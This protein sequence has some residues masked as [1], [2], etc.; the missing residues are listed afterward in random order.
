MRAIGKQIDNRFGEMFYGSLFCNRTLKDASIGSFLS[1]GW[2][3]GFA[4]EFVGGALEPAVKRL[5]NAPTPTRALIRDATT[6][7][8]N[9]F[10]YAATAMIFNA[11]VNKSMT[12]ED[13]SGMDYI[14]PRIG[15]L[16]PDGSPRRISNP[17]YT[18]EVPMAMKNIEE[19]QSV[20][21]GL[22]QMLSHKLMFAP[23]VEMGTNRNY[24]GYQIYDENAPGFKQA[25]QF[26]KHLFTEQL[27]PMSITGAK[28]SLELSGKPHTA[29]DILKGA[30]SGDSDVWGPVMGFGPAPAYASKDAIDNRISYLFN[31]FIAPKEKPFRESEVAKERA[32]A[33]TAYMMARQRGDQPAIAEAAKKLATLGVKTQQIMKM[34]PGGNI[35]Y[36]FQRLPESQ[37]VDLLKQMPPEKF[38]QFYPKA[39]RKTRSDPGVI[40]LTRRYFQQSP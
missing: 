16:N 7:S 14:F 35:Q 25:Y 36:M 37:Q 3:L 19:R 39:S 10:L 17:F 26:G 23:F 8:T 6:K 4:R 21:G 22:A 12:G 1:L 11:M 30:L 28:R 5:G 27:S 20:I 15:G 13:A 32:E 38:K 34:Q 2:N 31:K 40:A 33:R 24:Y 9:V 18:R 29:A